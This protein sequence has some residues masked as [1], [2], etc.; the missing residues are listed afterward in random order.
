MEDKSTQDLLYDLYLNAKMRDFY[1][2]CE[3]KDF[4]CLLAYEGAKIVNALK[5]RY[6]D[7]SDKEKELILG[8]IEKIE[9]KKNGK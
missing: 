7:L 5:K 1:Y 9:K 3:D 6:Q 2:E 8:K 4:F